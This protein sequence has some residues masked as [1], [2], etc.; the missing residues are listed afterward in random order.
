[1]MAFVSFSLISI[2]SLIPNSVLLTLAFWSIDSNVHEDAHSSLFTKL[3]PTIN[4][5]VKINHFVAAEIQSHGSVLVKEVEPKV[6]GF[7][8]AA[9][10]KVIMNRDGGDSPTEAGCDCVY[11]LPSCTGEINARIVD[12]CF[13]ND[14][15][16]LQENSMS[17]DCATEGWHQYDCRDVLNNPAASCKT[18]EMECCGVRTVS[19][20]CGL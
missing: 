2:I 10:N 18:I 1:M 7:G 15:V 13:P 3:Q 5:D 17:E 8:I 12:E 6:A 19:A 16:S 20:Y 14:G 4:R 9:M 11:S